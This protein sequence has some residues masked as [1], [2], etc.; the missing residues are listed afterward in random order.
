VVLVLQSLRAQ[1][2]VIVSNSNYLNL[3]AIIGNQKKH[4]KPRGN[5]KKSKR[6]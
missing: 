6:T 3:V 2:R 1:Q 5:Y 4:T